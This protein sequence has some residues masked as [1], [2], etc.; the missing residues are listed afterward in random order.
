MLLLLALCCCTVMVISTDITEYPKLL[1]EKL[2]LWNSEK[3]DFDAATGQQKKKSPPPP[4]TP[5]S[6]K[7][8]TS[9]SPPPPE[10]ED[11]C[12]ALKTELQ[13]KLACPSLLA[14]SLEAVKK[15]DASLFGEIA[16]HPKYKPLS[17]TE[18]ASVVRQCP[19]AAGAAQGRPAP[20]FRAAARP[21]NSIRRPPASLPPQL[22]RRGRVHRKA[23]SPSGSWAARRGPR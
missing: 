16:N 21:A 23:C 12:T 2:K 14:K 7:A 19:R 4:P 9:S 17:S 15:Y 5:P 8:E 6:T 1:D 11:K 3:C 10:S 20:A 18:R 13:D 22:P